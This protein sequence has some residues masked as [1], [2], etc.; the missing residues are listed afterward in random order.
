MA[1]IGF[2]Q[3]ECASCGGPLEWHKEDNEFVC[4]YCGNRY[5]RTESYD[6]SFSVR[7][8]A[9]QVLSA[10]AARNRKLAEEGINNCQMIDPS[11]VGT[12]VARLVFQ[13][14]VAGTE[15]ASGDAYASKNAITQA[16]EQ[17]RRLPVPFDATTCVD[18]AEFYDTIEDADARSL[19]ITDFKMLKDTGRIAY[20]EQAFD[21][22]AVHDGTV[23]NDAL[24]RASAEGRWE[25]FDELVSSSADYDADTVFRM[26]ILD[27]PDTESKVA[28][29]VQVADRGL[30]HQAAREALSAYLAGSDDAPETKIGIVGVMLWRGIAPD[31][32][33]VGAF[34]VAHPE[35]ENARMLIG[36]YCEAEQIDADVEALLDTLMRQGT[37]AQII[38]TIE[39]LAASDNYLTFGQE[40]MCTLLERGDMQLEDR[41]SCYET[42]SRC[43][44]TIKR[45]QSILAAL[46]DVPAGGD[47]AKAAIVGAI[48]QDMDAL[49]PTIIEAYL[50]EGPDAGATKADIVERLLGRTTAR[51]SLSYATRRYAESSSDDRET[52]D[53]V[54]S[55]L[56][57]ENLVDWS[58]VGNASG[59]GGAA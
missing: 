11:Y 55:V 22:S 33:A 39:T 27:H 32:G 13:L 56:A 45:K 48:V 35:D 18:E 38:Q 47:G 41:L 23:A 46:L 21:A 28:E 31:G 8:S 36:D 54:L 10:V 57:R 50:M 19:L 24:G 30:N 15:Q 20:I 44:L 2:T 14:F 43:G 17:F 4:T 25:Q 3:R 37:A 6:G 51:A 26:L 16:I 42:A 52:R 5:E 58:A 7:H 53:R 40:S 12:V 9:R 49:N 29:L 34:A 59:I 1:K